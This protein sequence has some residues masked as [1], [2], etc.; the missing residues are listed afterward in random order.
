VYFFVKTD[1]PRPTFHLD[2]TPDERATMVRHVAY[3]TDLARE[4]VSVLFGPV[5]D[6]GGWFGIGVHRVDDEAQMR[7]LL[8]ADPANGL[9]RYQLFPM[10]NLVLGH[11]V[12]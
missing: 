10:A 1:N 2:M 9:L 6:P 12:R 7:R 5:A 3:W 8:D 4:G 11:E